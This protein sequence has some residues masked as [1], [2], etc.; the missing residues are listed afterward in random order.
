[1]D[2]YKVMLTPRAYRDIES[3]Y[4]YI[5]RELQSPNNAKM[6]TERLKSAIKGLTSFPHAHQERQFGRF[7]DQ[8]YR[9]LLT[10]NYLAIF[11]IDENDKSIYVITVQYHGRNI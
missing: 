5:A 11:R 9:Q 8:G 2:K 1:M 7:A 10:D 3:I 4:V 6:Q